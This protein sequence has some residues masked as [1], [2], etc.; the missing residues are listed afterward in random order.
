MYLA[1]DMSQPSQ[2]HLVLFESELVA[3]ITTKGANA[4]VLT[5]MAD[6]LAANN[7]EAKSLHGIAIVMGEG[8]FTSTRLSVTVAN[9]VQYVYDTPLL[10]ITAA[11]LSDVATLSERF[12][13]DA[14][15]HY[16]S[17][18]YSAEPRIGTK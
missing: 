5:V 7:I 2:I 8:T 16:L 10:D 13:T 3:E 9:T 6:F 18:T 11:E 17:A 14:K 1:I 12:K 4:D 15:D